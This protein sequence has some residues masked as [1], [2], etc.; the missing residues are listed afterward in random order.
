MKHQWVYTEKQENILLNF[1]FM[2]REGTSQGEELACWGKEEVSNFFL[3][4]LAI[5]LQSVYLLEQ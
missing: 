1:A 5:V 4:P 3:V 2:G